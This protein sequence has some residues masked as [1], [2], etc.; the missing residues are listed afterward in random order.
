MTDRKNGA[1]IAPGGNRRF[2]D[3]KSPVVCQAIIHVCRSG[4]TVNAWKVSMKLEAQILAVAL[5]GACGSVFRL[6]LY[7]FCEKWSRLGFPLGTLCA[8]A[9]GCFLAGL[10]L[11]AGLTEGSPAVRFGLGVGFLGGLTTFSTFSMETV[12]HLR[13]N[14]WAIAFGNVAA[15]VILGLALV[16]LGVYLGKKW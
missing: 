12:H 11:G 3:W 2:D 7:L 13:E 8:N 9:I 5:G 1:A 4:F 10:L 6:G 14:A 16:F 15:N